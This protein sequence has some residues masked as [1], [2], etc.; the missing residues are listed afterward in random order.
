MCALYTLRINY[1]ELL[2]SFG[3]PLAPVPPM[4]DL[5]HRFLPH[6]EAPIFRKRKDQ[7]MLEPMNFS[8]IPAWSK[9]RRPKFATHN[10]RLETLREKPTWKRPLVSQHCLVPISE[11]IEPIYEGPHAGHMVGFSTPSSPVLWAAGLW[12]EWIDAASGLIIPSFTIITHEPSPFV[13]EMGHDREPLFLSSETFRPWLDAQ[14]KNS[15][16]W[17][18]FLKNSHR[19]PELKTREDRKLKGTTTPKKT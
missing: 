12:D 13:R 1:Q 15:T 4:D 3:L 16:D 7:Y 2:N 6:Q 9:E 10:A 19:E 17:I 8:L 14:E 11:F 18:E 5:D